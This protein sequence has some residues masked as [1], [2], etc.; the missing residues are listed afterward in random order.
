MLLLLL[1]ANLLSSLSR[2]LSQLDRGAHAMY[3]SPALKGYLRL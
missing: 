1:I 2:E 3:L